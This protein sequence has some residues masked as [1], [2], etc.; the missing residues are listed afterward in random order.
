MQNPQQY[1]EQHVT[2]NLDELDVSLEL[3]ATN[4]ATYGSFNGKT[5]LHLISLPI[6]ARLDYCIQFMLF[7]FVKK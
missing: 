4:A 1:N 7:Y 2:A 3:T 6:S 5:I